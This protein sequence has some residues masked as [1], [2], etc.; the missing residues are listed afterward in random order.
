MCRVQRSSAFVRSDIRAGDVDEVDGRDI[1]FLR[2]RPHPDDAAVGKM[3][4]TTVWP[5][6][7]FFWDGVIRDCGADGVEAVDLVGRSEGERACA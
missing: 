5:V 2:R 6:A 4:E 3:T 7:V 1:T